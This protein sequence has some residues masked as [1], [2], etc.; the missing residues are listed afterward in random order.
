M[1]HGK[2]KILKYKGYYTEIVFG[3]NTKTVRGKIEGIK[4]LIDFETDDLS[5]I[6]KEFHLAVDEYLRFCKEVGKKPN[7]KLNKKYY[8]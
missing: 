7:N 4:D 8:N 3:S 5:K 2:N 1:N 6:E